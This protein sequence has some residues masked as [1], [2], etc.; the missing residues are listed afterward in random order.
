MPAPKGN[1]F[2]EARSSYGRTKAFEAP[3]TLWE[4]CIE[5]FNWVH[6]NPLEKSI[7]YQGQVNESQVETIMRA[8]TIDGLCTFLDIDVKTWSNYRQADGYEEYFQVVSKV[9]SII[10]TQK[11]EGAAAGL[12]N[13]NIIAR[14]LGLRDATTNE[15]TGPNGSALPTPSYTFVGVAAD[16][17]NKDEV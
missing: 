12:L 15:H 9:E 11:F 3:E 17:E 7:V 14:D 10:R 6:E 13:P 8:M 2:W 1:K 4:S 16:R 5:Y